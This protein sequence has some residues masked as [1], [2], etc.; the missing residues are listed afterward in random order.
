[1]KLNIK[2]LLGHMVTSINELANEGLDG[3]MYT[4]NDE[5]AT[6]SADTYEIKRRRSHCLV[7]WCFWY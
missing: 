1:M 6:R 7:L 5:H 4:V 3:W 2:R